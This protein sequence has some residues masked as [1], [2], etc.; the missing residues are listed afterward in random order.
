M[1]KRSQFDLL[2]QLIA[3]VSISPDDNGAQ[4]LIHQYLKNIF[5]D[6]VE[7][8]E[9]KIN[10]TTNSMINIDFKNEK[11]VI[12]VGHTDVV[13]AQE[14]QWNTPP[15]KLTVV[16]NQ[17]IGRG[18][19]DMK[20]AIVAFIAA[21]ENIFFDLK[22]ECPNIC[23]LL[24][25][26]EEGSGKD[27]LQK[28]AS[29]FNLKQDSIAIIGEPTSKLKVGDC[30][31]I[32]RRGSL[33]CLLK[34]EGES[35]HVA[36]PGKNHPVYY[37]EDLIEQLKITDWDDGVVIDSFEPSSFQITK[38]ETEDSVEN[39]IPSTL[40]IRFNIR[41]SPVTN[42][43]KVEKILDKIL[44]KIPLKKIINWKQG[45]TPWISSLTN[46]DVKVIFKDLEIEQFTTDGGVSDGYKV[47]NFFTKKIIEIGLK[48]EKAHQRNESILLEDFERLMDIYQKILINIQEK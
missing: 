26:D 3:C 32:G 45:A 33:H 30:A 29:T 40:I 5:S 38:I 42:L 7:I 2:S 41:Y 1:L 25:S 24:T 8:I 9:K 4:A 14:S 48:H 20:G 11:T 18:I 16:D 46:D 13:P 27:G 44:E 31:K 12:F 15:F 23:F 35:Y 37:I 36:Y 34:L 19:S 17:L 43:K 6:K 28:L 47:Y 22:K 21:L 39:V 10:Q